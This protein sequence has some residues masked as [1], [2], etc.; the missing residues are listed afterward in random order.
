MAIVAS[1]LE[2]AFWSI[3]IPS[4][5][6]I[7]MKL[8]SSFFYAIGKLLFWVIDILQTVFRKLAGLDTI[9][10]NGEQTD[11]DILLSIFRSQV[12]VDTLISV[13]VF[14]VALV[15][16]AT[17]VQMVRTEYTTEGSRNSKEG[18]LGQALKSLA[19]F[20]LI[21]VVCF[22]GIR[23]SNY[24]LQ[25]VDYATSSGG[26][27]SISGA[28][29][30]A[31]T[32]SAN[33]V[34]NKSDG[35]HEFSDISISGIMDWIL[36]NTDGVKGVKY[37]NGAIMNF[38]DTLKSNQSDDT[39]A[40]QEIGKKID[41][42][43][44]MNKSSAK[45]FGSAGY[46]E[47]VKP[48]GEIYYG[49]TAAVRY[50][51]DMGEINYIILYFGAFVVL[52]ALFNASMGLVVRMYKATAL[53]VIAP[54]AI[55]L[56]PL[57]GGN[58]FKSWKKNFLSS[59]LAAY[60]VIV[61]LNIFFVVAGVVSQIELWN[62]KDFINYG[63]NKFMQALFVIV[64]A[65]QIK[66]LA[67]TIN[68]LI[69]SDTDLIS[70]GASATGDATKLVGSV[71]KTG[72]GAGVALKA[73]AHRVAG[74]GHSISAAITKKKAENFAKMSE[75][76]KNAIT[77]SKVYDANVRSNVRR[78]KLNGSTYDE[79]TGTW[80]ARDGS[81]ITDKRTIKKYDKLRAADIKDKHDA[82]NWY[83]IKQK[84][85][86]ESIDK[87]R[88][89]SA[90]NHAKAGQGFN[91]V[92]G[93]I[94]D[95]DPAK[96]LMGLT[97][98]SVFKSAAN[99]KMF[100]D[101]DEEYAK[102]GIP[103]KAGLKSGTKLAGG[104][105]K[106]SNFISNKLTETLVGGAIDYKDARVALT[107]T[108]NEAQAVFDKDMAKN[109]EYKAGFLGNA[110]KVAGSSLG[111]AH[112]E[113]ATMLQTLMT[114]TSLDSGIAKKLA[115]DILTNLGSS[116]GAFGADFENALRNVSTNGSAGLDAFRR[117]SIKT[118]GSGDDLKAYDTLSAKN[119]QIQEA[120]TQE[121]QLYDQHVNSFD[122]KMVDNYTADLQTALKNV[123]D[124]GPLK[125]DDDETQA[126]I[127][128]LLT[129]GIITSP[130]DADHPLKLDYNRL[131]QTISQS[132]AKQQQE[133][134]ARAKESKAMAEQTKLLKD[135][136]KELKKKK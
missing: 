3:I 65:T 107:Q 110:A 43:M 53:F 121:S 132:I 71:A 32:I 72:I 117:E 45:K 100:K 119:I 82:T 11:G 85:F 26:S 58:A 113:S 116:I 127:K 79:G 50:F 29:F 21:P 77:A 20:I 76:E 81:T 56:Q 74:V 60:G 80:K 106:A 13:T 48:T 18:I 30:N 9:W 36:P 84:K 93:M 54:A 123:I 115:T 91:A 62:P 98:G 46:G 44:A 112:T 105:D 104:L 42:L 66:G 52:Q 28:I 78:G 49:N 7:A 41:Q 35:E 23:V 70:E 75:A 63:L 83:S 10:M 86:N 51:Y 39:K 17:I 37:E 111:T 101:Y 5:I 94:M 128:Q 125:I 14:A 129:Q 4:V 1:G 68:T 90:L 130:S 15:I 122:K 73:G 27:Q 64:G 33:K 96:T 19:M 2:I 34:V 55:G 102:T 16:V 69:G 6:G 109:N 57:D 31:S 47:G 59:V 95:S 126:A 87:S 22:F 25:A 12:V 124:S 120:K 38:E 24:L 114:D 131:T 92:A 135:M 67:K 136:V 103:Q 61:A 40:R 8:F 108:H 99:G 118:L 97:G 89:L 133:D 134:A 88:Q